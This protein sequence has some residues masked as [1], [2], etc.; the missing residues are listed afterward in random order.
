LTT[1]KGQHTRSAIDEIN[2]RHAFDRPASGA[3]DFSPGFP[4]LQVKPLEGPGRQVSL[5]A[6]LHH[7]AL[8]IFIDD[9]A[10]VFATLFFPST[11]YDTIIDRRPRN[12]PTRHVRRRPGAPCLWLLGQERRFRGNAAAVGNGRDCAQ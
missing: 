1:I 2:R 6:F 9:G 5:H 4:D 12:R 7:A 8:E 3:M 10:T 11:P